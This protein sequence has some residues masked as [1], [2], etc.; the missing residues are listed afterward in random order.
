MADEK[1]EIEE[2]V[3]ET[4]EA[5]KRRPRSM[6]KWNGGGVDENT[7]TE[8]PAQKVEEVKREPVK[9]VEKEPVVKKEAAEEL[10]QEPEI[11]DGME[12]VKVKIIKEYFVKIRSIIT[13]E[14]GT[15]ED[16]IW[17]YPVKDK[18]TEYETQ[19][20][21]PNLEPRELELVAEKKGKDV[22]IFLTPKRT[23]SSIM[24]DGKKYLMRGH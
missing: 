2:V 9:V 6:P 7:E 22:S 12:T 4:V 3:A 19:R 20:S 13:Y 17:E 11:D 21:G 14:D 8:E 18:F 16:K 1:E 10:V 5:P 15:S 24:V 23:I